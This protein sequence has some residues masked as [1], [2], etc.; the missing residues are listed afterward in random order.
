MKNVLL[1]VLLGVAL[2][3]LAGW[4]IKISQPQR[5]EA[6]AVNIVSVFD[7]VEREEQYATGSTDLIVKEQASEFQSIADIMKVKSDFKQTELLYALAGRAKV[8]RLVALTKEADAIADSSDR[9][10]ALSILFSRLTELSPELALEAVGD[11]RFLGDESLSRSIWRTWARLDFDS[12]L[13]AVTELTP[14]SRKESAARAMYWAVGVFGNSKT[15]Q[16]KAMTGV[17]PTLWSISQTIEAIAR[18]SVPEAI[19]KINQ[20]HSVQDQRYVANAVA[21]LAAAKAP[22]LA[23][24]HAYLF[25]SGGVRDHYRIAVLRTI[26]SNSPQTVLQNW[27]ESNYQS[28]DVQGIY[29][30]LTQYAFED[31]EQAMSYVDQMPDSKTKTGLIKVLLAVK[32]RENAIDA[33]SLAQQYEQVGNEGLVNYLVTEMITVS[34]A[35]ALL[36][37][38][39]L[40]DIPNY[41][42]HVARA[43]GGLAQLDPNKAVAKIQLLSDNELRELA[44]QELVVAWA[45]IDVNAALSYALTQDSIGKPVGVPL[46]DVDLDL[47]MR[48]LDKFSS[49]EFSINVYTFA[50]DLAARYSA[51]E[52]VGT[53]S[54]YRSNAQFD[55]I[56]TSILSTLST[57]SDRD[58]QYFIDTFWADDE[59]SFA[60][61]SYAQTIAYK[62]PEVALNMLGKLDN[63]EDQQSLLQ[64]VISRTSYR[65]KN[66][67]RQMLSRLESAELRDIAVSTLSHRFSPDSKNDIALINSIEEPRVRETAILNMLYASAKTEGMRV[68]DQAR[69]LGLSQKKIDNL[70]LLV[71]CR[72]ADVHNSASRRKCGAVLH[73]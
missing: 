40:P 17:N 35:S 12:A 67:A 20:L 72:D 71:E 27:S 3:V 53:L 19:V 21:M 68:V 62:N 38:E 24:S 70:K 30:A 45:Q 7:R 51:S 64:M 47:G 65:D 28:K 9:S 10:Y 8:R 18:T 2:V 29:S 14:R 4:V 63:I 1:G 32:S 69:E 25:K 52:L 55:V 46:R 11:E 42:L 48:F 41:K 44:N 66:A 43:V 13:T 58:A 34:P 60:Y 39:A 22:E 61:L 33:L 36:A 49:P 6:E 23:L 59:K 5:S 15:E 31:F 50:A 73:K 26:G 37:L 56:K 57:G 16:I 54:P